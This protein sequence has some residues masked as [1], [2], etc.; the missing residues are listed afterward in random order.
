[1]RKA[2]HVVGI[3]KA[4]KFTSP[5]KNFLENF[6]AKDLNK[7]AHNLGQSMSRRHRNELANSSK[8][9]KAM[10]IVIAF[11]MSMAYNSK[12]EAAATAMLVVCL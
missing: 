10:F 4:Q 7:F 12:R 1:M 8:K 6:C 3:E 5:H 9:I 11:A 2:L